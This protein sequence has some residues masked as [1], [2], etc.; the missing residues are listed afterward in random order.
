[1]ILMILIMRT[2]TMKKKE[3]I[4]LPQKK[5]TIIPPP[6]RMYKSSSV[7]ETNQYIPSV[8]YMEASND[9]LLRNTASTSQSQLLRPSLISINNNQKESHFYGSSKQRGGTKRRG[10]GRGRGS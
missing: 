9:M 6:Q 5:P 4:D 2:M 3:I 1:M 8:S 7:P 10:R